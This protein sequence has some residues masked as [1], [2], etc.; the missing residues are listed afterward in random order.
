MYS[1]L[2]PCIYN[3]SVGSSVTFPCDARR[4][5]LM[6]TETIATQTTEQQGNL[7]LSDSVCLFEKTKQ[8]Q[9]ELYVCV[10]VYIERQKED[11][12]RTV[13]SCALLYIKMYSLFVGLWKERYV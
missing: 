3:Q 12:T 2:H 9:H 6:N 10:C 8:K 5:W 4:C 1:G 13:G 11:K 7:V